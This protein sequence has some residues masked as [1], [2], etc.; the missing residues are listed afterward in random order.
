VS[1][2][3]GRFPLSVVL[4]PHAQLPLQV[5]EE[6]YRALME[7]CM[8]G[9][10]Q[11]GVVLI[12]RGSEVGG[13]DERF[14]IGTVA[15]ISQIGVVEDGRVMVLA[16]GSHRCRVVRW[17]TDAPYPRAHL[18]A[19]PLE[20][21]DSD[22]GAVAI[23]ETSVRRLRSLLSEL[24]DL[25]SLPPDRVLPDDLELAGWRLCELAPL[26]PIDR[27]HLLTE[28]GLRGQMVMLTTLCDAQAQDVVALLSGRFGD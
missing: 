14:D 15:R 10:A 23:A 5:F 22:A 7:D 18:V 6:R 27:Q 17:S 24:G 2:L 11:F 13:G 8:A 4:F 19:Y 26:G 3:T 1:G 12:S 25:P 9:D 16:Q 28:P 21:A 20:R